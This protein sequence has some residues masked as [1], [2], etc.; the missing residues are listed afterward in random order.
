MRRRPAKL[1]GNGRTQCRH[2]SSPQPGVS[3]LTLA[4]LAWL[5]REGV[6]PVQ[7]C[8]CGG[9]LGALGTDQGASQLGQ[10]HWSV[11]YSEFYPD[12]QQEP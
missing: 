7:E 6:L 3:G 10:P 4:G 9:G 12:S 8:N 5:G 1:W 2:G 11:P